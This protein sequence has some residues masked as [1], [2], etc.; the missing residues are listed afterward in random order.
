M[1]AA[2]LALILSIPFVSACQTHSTRSPANM[3]CNQIPD[4]RK[5]AVLRRDCL[6]Q[7]SLDF[8]SQAGYAHMDLAHQIALTQKQAAIEYRDGRISLEQYELRVEEAKVA[9]MK[10]AA[11]RDQ[12]MTP[13]RVEVSLERPIYPPPPAPTYQTPYRLQHETVCRRAGYDIRCVT[14]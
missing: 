13:K 8:L 2:R 14:E 10:V 9:N 1:I 11:E 6:N 12:A 3:H 5:S 4:D 7:A